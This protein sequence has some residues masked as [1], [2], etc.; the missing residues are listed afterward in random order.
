[1]RDGKY[2]DDLSSQF[3]LY[4]LIITSKN[5]A[6][7]QGETRGVNLHSERKREKEI[8]DNGKKKIYLTPLG[9]TGMGLTSQWHVA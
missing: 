1:M 2:T 8:Q 9:V 3:P 7:W 6:E 4:H 5:R